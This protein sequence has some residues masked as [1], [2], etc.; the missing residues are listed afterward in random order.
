MNR[1]RL[2]VGEQYC[3]TLELIRFRSNIQHN[4]LYFIIEDWENLSYNE[5]SPHKVWQAYQNHT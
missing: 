4:E 1:R 5:D 2:L 3:H